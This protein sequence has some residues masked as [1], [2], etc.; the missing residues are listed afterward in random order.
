MA[1]HVFSNNAVTTLSAGISDS[2]ETIYL[3]SVVAFSQLYA[4]EVQALTISDPSGGQEPEIVL[5]YESGEGDQRT[6][7][8]GE[9][10][11]AAKA[12]PAGSI[13]SARV[14]AGMLESFDQTTRKSGVTESH[15]GNLTGVNWL[16]SDVVQS[17]GVPV[18]QYSAHALRT[19]ANV[20]HE[21]VASL[22]PVEL[23]TVAIWEAET[24]YKGFDIVVPPTPDG[25]QYC[26]QPA[27]KNSTS[28]KSS[29]DDADDNGAWVGRNVGNIEA[30]VMPDS[31]CAL[32][33]TEVGF[34]CT[35]YGSGSAPVVSIGAD[36]DSTRFAASV[37]LSQFTDGG[38]IH[39]IPV[40][41]GGALV[42]DRLQFSL[43]TPSSA[44]LVGMFYWRGFFVQVAM[45][46][47]M[48]GAW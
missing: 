13:V 16:G 22:M 15:A 8:R 30:Y 6:V 38:E 28:W 2:D 7:S 3:T 24:P 41:A 10:G 42:H 4:G 5:A 35:A 47:A 36:G 29:W 45:Q 39:R 19:E 33:V 17:G 40:P 34:I 12:W 43:V 48:P 11:T 9:D 32:V 27:E 44:S 37:A 18:L 14:T 25:M 26:F 20:S 23:G 46:V 1:R 31:L 21:V